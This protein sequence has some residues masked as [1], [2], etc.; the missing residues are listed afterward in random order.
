MVFF[1]S[2]GKVDC[3][4]IDLGILFVVLKT[5]AKCFLKALVNGKG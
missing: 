4:F 2:C 1:L 3:G 5:Y